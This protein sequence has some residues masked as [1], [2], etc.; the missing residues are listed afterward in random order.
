MQPVSGTD[1]EVH[2][3]TRFAFKTSVKEV[4]P[5]E[6]KNM[7]ELEFSERHS[8]EKLSLDDRRFL[9]KV[10]NDIHLRQDGHFEMGLPLK[11][12]NL[13]LPNNRTMA[14]KRLFSLRRKLSNDQQFCFD[15]MNFM[16]E[17][18]SK[19]YAEKV[20]AEVSNQD[21]GRVWYIPHHG[22]YQPRHISLIC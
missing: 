19:G 14:V 8:D 20:R 22:V 10:K 4:N 5:E 11:S 7:H 18:I 13:Q 2:K 6:I 17:L 9:Q 1:E 3:N 12:E 21:D 16:S 15:Y